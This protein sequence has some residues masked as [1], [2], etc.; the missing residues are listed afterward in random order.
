MMKLTILAMVASSGLAFAVQAAP[1]PQVCIAGSL[2]LRAVA[3][4]AHPADCCAGRMQCPHYLSTAMV[5]RP[6]RR[7]RT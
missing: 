3:I 4:V 6:A 5:V 7:M 2:G 1:A